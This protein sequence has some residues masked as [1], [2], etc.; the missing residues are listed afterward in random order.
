MCTAT[1]CTWRL[2]HALVASMRSYLQSLAS[3]LTVFTPNRGGDQDIKAQ[4]LQ[5]VSMGAY[6]RLTPQEI[7]RQIGTHMKY[8]IS[9]P[10]VVHCVYNSKQ[11]TV[12]VPVD[13]VFD[14]DSFKRMLYLQDDGLAWAVHDWLYHSHAFDTKPDGTTTTIDRSVVDEIMYSLL[15]LD[16]SVVYAK[17]LQLGDGFVAAILDQAWDKQTDNVFIPI[18]SS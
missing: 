1:R 6:V 3:K 14:G 8:R 13:R 18:S 4:T 16:G 10:I 11:E 17:L 7:T 9:K 5:I 12:T 2:C 15:V